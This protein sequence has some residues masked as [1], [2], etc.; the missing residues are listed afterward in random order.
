MAVSKQALLDALRK[1]DVPGLS[2][3]LLDLRMISELDVAPEGVRVVL[4]ADAREYAV[5]DPRRQQLAAVVRER[6]GA[7]AAGTPVD[8]VWKTP[9]ASRNIA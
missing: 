8:V 4:T 1:I 5:G 9:V 7:V 6:L 3:S 2:G